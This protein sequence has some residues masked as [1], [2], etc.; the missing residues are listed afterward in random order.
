MIEAKGFLKRFLETQMD[1]LTGHIEECG[2]P[3]N[4][5][6][7]GQKDF[8]TTNGTPNWWVYEQTGYWLDG[9]TR[10]AIAL[11]DKEKLK[12]AEKIIYN[13]INNP[14]HD[15]YLGPRNMKNEQASWW[16]HVVF[17]RSIIALYEYN[18]DIRLMNALREHYIN[19]DHCF[20][21]FR[22]VMNVEIILYVYSVLKDDKLLSMAIDIYRGYNEIEFKFNQI[23]DKIIL[24]K[25]K[26]EIHG[27]TYNE[28]SK[29]GAL[30]FKYTKDKYYLDISIQSYQNL[31]KYYMLPGCCNCSN[32]Q[33]HSSYYYETYETCD[34]SD[35]SY[36]NE[37]MIK[38]TKKAIY[39]DLVEQCVFN[40]GIGSVLENFRGL[41]YFSCANQLILDNSSN[42]DRFN[43]GKKWMS[44]R[45]N[46]G[47]ECCPGNVNRFM[48]NYVLNM[49][50]L[51]DSN[52]YINLFGESYFEEIIEEK[53][54]KLTQITNFPFDENITFN[55]D[56]NASFN[57]FIRKPQYASS[58]NIS[59][60]K[61]LEITS[62]EDYYQV[63]I[64]GSCQIN[65]SFDS[66]IK[67]IKTNKN[68]VYLKKGV[69]V[70]S[71]G[72]FGNRCIDETE[73]RSSNEF[74]AFKIYPNQEFGYALNINQLNYNFVRRIPKMFDLSDTMPYIEL[75]A[76]K[77]TNY[78]FTRQ[79][80]VR[81]VKVNW[82]DNTREIKYEKGD[83][84]FTPDILKQKIE[85]SNQKKRIRL[86]PYGACK[87]RETVFRLL[88]R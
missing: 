49:Y 5:V 62:N 72:M 63:K 50:Y 43:K 76:Y 55:V 1:G 20:Y 48:P 79:K 65:Y 52:L 32:E 30:L 66:E 83:F 11:G 25:K 37:Q 71:Y 46:P 8:N 74:P 51:E 36:S 58:I 84:V 19:A 29:L 57:L 87:I 3:F 44:Y 16:P 67:V 17:F 82:F 80:R 4:T 12:R 15:G 85:V 88:N 31:L 10:C 61:N 54:V 64:N 77:I 81:R 9:Y 78:D 60:D 28:Y 86:Y 21:Y 14:D 26:K 2:Y 75:D 22:D 39:G 47:T 68:G 70:Y 41:Q 7:W 56:T 13:V 23:N 6:E 18:H 27:V 24:S 45:P 35:F 33:T 42:H 38:I 69:L 59:S 40:A 73:E 53:I 34:V